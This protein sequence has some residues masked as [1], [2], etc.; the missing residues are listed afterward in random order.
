MGSSR[1]RAVTAEQPL[2]VRKEGPRYLT[3][4][5]ASLAGFHRKQGM[6]V[7]SRDLLSPKPPSSE[8]CPGIGQFVAPCGSASIRGERPISEFH[9]FG[10]GFLPHPTVTGRVTFL[11]SGQALNVGAAPR[12]AENPGRKRLH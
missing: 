6:L 5:F 8:A 12:D 10:A 11:A 7:A 4:C 2:P 1:G 3:V 9:G